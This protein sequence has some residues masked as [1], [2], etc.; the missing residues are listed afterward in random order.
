MEEQRRKASK[1]GQKAS[2]GHIAKISESD[3]VV[4]FVRSEDACE[5]REAYERNTDLGE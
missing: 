5:H 1:G 4:T 3:P 2:L